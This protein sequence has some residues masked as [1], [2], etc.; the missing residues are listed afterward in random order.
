MPEKISLHNAPFDLQKTLECGQTFFWNRMEDGGEEK[1][2]TVRNGG[3]LKVWQGGETLFYENIGGRIDPVEVLRLEDPLDEIYEE[4]SRDGFIESAVQENRGL[5]IIR[6][7]FFSC[8]I[9][10][11]TSAQ[12]RIPRIKRIQNQLAERFGE[13]LV[14]DRKY[15]QFPEPEKLASV[16]LEE[17]K[18][19]GLGYRAKYVKGSAEM[20]RDGEVKE[21][22]MRKMAYTE[23]K[24]E[25]MKLPGVGDKVADCVLLFSLDFLQAFP[26]DTWIRKVAKKKYPGLYAKKYRETSKT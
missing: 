9:S 20:I 17:L 8:L 26:I 25:L 2:Y 7:R 15:R 1:Y 23:A 22:E 4:I 13:E 19:L 12:M 18:E 14:L 5:R 3:V 21:G 24:E 16:P 11:I 10:Y 6:D